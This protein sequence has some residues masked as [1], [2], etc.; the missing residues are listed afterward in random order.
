[1]IFLLVKVGENVRTANEDARAFIRQSVL[2]VWTTPFPAFESRLAL[3]AR[4]S[5]ERRERDARKAQEL[6]SPSTSAPPIPATKV[7]GPPRR[8]VNH[9]VM[10]LPNSAI[11]FLDA[12]RGLY[13]PL[14]E[15]EGAKEAIE[16]AG[17]EDGLP[18]VHC[19]CFTK[20]VEGAEADILAVR[21]RFFIVSSES[22]MR[23]DIGCTESFDSARSAVD[24]SSEGFQVALHSRCCTEEGDVLSRVQAVVGDGH[25]CSIVVAVISIIVLAFF[26]LRYFARC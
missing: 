16:A 10:N 14:L 2:D 26:R 22:L 8:L 5:L 6:V 17:G 13:T 20:D 7:A 9:F 18:L 21:P 23:S 11:E 15:L 25:Y 4:E 24:G 12:Y 3:K 1:M 19:Y